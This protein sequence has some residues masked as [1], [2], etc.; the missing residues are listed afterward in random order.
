MVGTSKLDIAKELFDSALYHYYETKSYYS[1]IHLAGAAEEILGAFVTANNGESSFEYL[2]NVTITFAEILRDDGTKP[3][4]KEI[5]NMLNYP[6]NSTK[7]MNDKGDDMVY[8]AA[9]AAAK[10]LL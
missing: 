2:K 9:K 6:K 3:K 4:Q 10:D 8:F 7:H 5:A 1:A